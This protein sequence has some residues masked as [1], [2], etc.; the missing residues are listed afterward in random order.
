MYPLHRIINALGYNPHMT[1]YHCDSKVCNGDVLTVYVHGYGENPLISV[2][3][4]KSNSK[5]LPGTVF[6]FV[7]QDASPKAFGGTQLHR[8][9]VGQEDDIATLAS[10]LKVLDESG[11][12]VLNLFGTSRGGAT[13]VTTLGRLCSY[14]NFTSFFKRLDITEVQAARIINKVKKGTIV[15]NCPLVDSR[16]V[17]QHWFGKKA[18]KFIVEKIIPKITLHKPNSDQ[19]IDYAP[20]LQMQEF[21]ILVH[22][23][24]NDKIVGNIK[25]IEFYEKIMG[26]DSYLTLGNDG[27]HIHSGESLGKAVMAFNKLYG[28]AYYNDEEILAIGKSIL[29]LSPTCN[30]NV[31]HF[32]KSTYMTF[33]QI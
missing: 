12:E 22:F 33:N 31:A 24:H 19:A 3:F 25:D 6:T 8:S 15:L 16:A 29:D 28:N 4:F 23:E 30:N 9:S 10:M 14:N 1:I 7:F 17:A 26:P 32:V 13:T 20:I 27:G 18:G 2:P 11:I 5:L 21:R